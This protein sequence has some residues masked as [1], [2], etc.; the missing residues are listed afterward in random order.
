MKRLSLVLAMFALV[1]SSVH[2]QTPT[3]GV[4][5]SERE[6]V[7]PDP[8]QTHVRHDMSYAEMAELMGM[9]DRRRFSKVIFNQAEWID[10]DEPAFGWDAAARYGGDYNKVWIEAEGGRSEGVTD[11]SRVELGWERIVSR[12]WSLR[13]G[14]RQDGGIGPSRT[15]AAI[16]LEGLA[17]GFIVMDASLYVGESGRTALRLDAEYDLR[18]TQRLVFQPE[19][20]LDVHGKDDPERLIGAGLSTAEFGLRLRY[21]IRREFAPYLGIGW[22]WRFGDT[23]D[24]ARASGEDSSEFAFRAGLR[25]WF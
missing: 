21:E 8:P 14:V 1:A 2:A 10:A 23:A 13:A 6:H 12:W 11:D 25:A 5:D 7:A 9:D 4:N 3:Q 18:I 22:N 20:E 15:W 16:G 17:P 19:L 24:L